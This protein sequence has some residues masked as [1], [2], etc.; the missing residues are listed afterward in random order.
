MLSFVLT[1]LLPAAVPAVSS[2]PDLADQATVLAAPIQEVTVFSD[3]ARVKRTGSARLE[4]GARVLRLPDL[5]GATLLNTVHVSATGGQVLRVE[6]APVER[7]RM[8]IDQVDALIGQLETISDRLA[9]ID[10]EQAVLNGELDLLRRTAP[11]QAPAEKDRT[12]KTPPALA[13]DGWTSSLDFIAAREAMVLEASRALQVDRARLV[14]TYQKLQADAARYDLGALS[15]RRIQVLAIVEVAQAGP[16]SLE[17]VYLVPGAAWWPAYDLHFSP[18]DGSVTLD[19]AGQ[20]QQA[21]GEAWERVNL[22]LSTSIPGQDIQLP[23]LL[24]WTLGERK[25][26]MPRPRPE[27][28]PAVPPR[29]AAPQPAP[30]PLEAERR[31]RQELLQQRLALLGNLLATDAR[32]SATP[33]TST[34]SQPMVKPSPSPRRSAAPQPRPVTAAEPEEASIEY[35]ARDDDMSFAE[36]PAAPGAAMAVDRAPAAPI[37]QAARGRR[38]SAEA[39]VSTSL[40][41]FD[42]TTWRKPTFGDPTLPAVVAGGLDYSYRATTPA[43]VASDGQRLRVPLARASYQASLNYETTPALATTAYLTAKVENRGRLPILRG[44]VNIFVGGAFTSEGVLQTTGPGGSLS[45]P[46]GADED[47]RVVHHVAAKTHTSGVLIKDEITE[48]TTRIEIGNFK[49]RPIAID[50]FDVLPQTSTD[51]MEIKLGAARPALAEKPDARG[52]LRWR[53]EIAPKKTQT[54]TFTYTVKRPP[55]WQ[56]RQR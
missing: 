36:M 3:R 37:A 44:P 21:S 28:T 55:N 22:V 46:L 26:F 27:Q 52:R 31:S 9:R 54:I 8:S 48:Y 35:E 24:T 47:I 4:R 14:E 17:L 25:D 15:D 13:V 1:V 29:F 20:V 32:A 51:K 6:I 38:S 50:V 39:R 7:E 18:K 42:P 41:L 53:L 12:G 5:P 34:V 10:A 19:T 16:V 2:G 23:E 11:K 40:A 30:H 56:L 33:V 49:N 45:L 43:T